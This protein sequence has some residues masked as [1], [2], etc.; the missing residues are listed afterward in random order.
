MELT[1]KET[2]NKWSGEAGIDGTWYEGRIWCCNRELSTYNLGHWKRDGVHS[3]TRLFS[4]T[5][6]IG[7]IEKR[8]K[9]THWFKQ[10]KEASIIGH[11]APL[12]KQV[13]R[14][15]FPTDHIEIPQGL[16]VSLSV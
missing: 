3:G 1:G 12:L 9:M 11:T 2:E 6:P 8:Q 14:R 16:E 4:T 5:R 13:G 7:S 15:P 10:D